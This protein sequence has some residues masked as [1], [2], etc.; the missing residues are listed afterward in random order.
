MKSKQITFTY[1]CKNNLWE[2]IT[3]TGVESI[4]RPWPILFF[5]LNNGWMF[6]DTNSQKQEFL[7]CSFSFHFKQHSATFSF[8]FRPLLVKFLFIFFLKIQRDWH[9]KF[10][11]QWGD[12]CQVRCPTCHLTPATCLLNGWQMS[13]KNQWA[14]EKK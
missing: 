8:Y 2:I 14:G 7:Y 6:L 4:F 12:C 13:L 3:K 10:C 9:G 5:I 11:P 1:S